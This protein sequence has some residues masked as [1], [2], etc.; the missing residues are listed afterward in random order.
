MRAILFLM[1]L[2]AAGRDRTANT[3]EVRAEGRLQPN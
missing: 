3:F 2:L 1:P